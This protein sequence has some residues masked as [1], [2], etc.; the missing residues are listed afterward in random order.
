M[1]AKEKPTARGYKNDA[2]TA[3]V[4]RAQ[5]AGRRLKRDTDGWLSDAKTGVLIGP[6]PAI[7]AELTDEML[8]RAEIVKGG[9]VVQRGRP[10]LGD[11][12]KTAV[13]LRLDKTILAAYRATGPGWQSRINADLT[14]TARKIKAAQ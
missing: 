1:T 3:R 12:P 4:R 11:Q 9:K 14:K 6:D 10:P 13:T 7:E 8:D 5:K 2:L